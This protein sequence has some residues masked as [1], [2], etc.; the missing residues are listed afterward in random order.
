MK[1]KYSSQWGFTLIELIVV[2]VIIAILAM[3]TI[4]SYQ[5][6]IRRSAASQAQQQ[7]MQIEIELKQHKARNFNYLNFNI[8]PS[9]TTVPKSATQ[10]NIKYRLTAN[11]GE[12]KSWVLVAQ[13]LDPY[14]YSFLSSSTGLRCKNTT[15]NNIDAKK[16]TCGT[17]SESW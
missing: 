17:G 1:Y 13:S 10:A 12:G 15:W 8:P 6:Y 16:L 9:L 14:N 2:I 5:T 3:V 11:T 4:P 7:L